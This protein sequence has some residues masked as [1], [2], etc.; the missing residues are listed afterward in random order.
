M[1]S[2]DGNSMAVNWIKLSENKLCV[3]FWVGTELFKTGTS[4]GAI[5]SPHLPRQNSF[6]AVQ[7]DSCSTH[8]AYPGFEE[9]KTSYILIK[10]Q[11]SSLLTL[12]SRRMQVSTCRQA[13]TPN[14]SK[15]RCNG[16]STKVKRDGSGRA[17]VKA[18]CSSCGKT[19]TSTRFC[20]ATGMGERSSR[21]IQASISRRSWSKA[22]DFSSTSR[23]PVKIRHIVSLDTGR[24]PR[25]TLQELHLTAILQDSSRERGEPPRIKRGN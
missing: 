18:G 14:N 22:L 20:P 8:P 4:E 13:S 10:D 19:S 25:L 3:F 17:K 16:K 2:T 9:G 23:E 11:R 5:Y 21:Y 6:Q 7:R 24:T 15:G 1:I 12:C